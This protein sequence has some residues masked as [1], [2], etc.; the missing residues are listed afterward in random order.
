MAYP[1]DSQRPLS[2][3]SVTEWMRVARAPR[4]AGDLT[5][6][7]AEEVRVI[8]ARS[9]VPAS[10]LDLKPPDVVP[11]FHPAD[12]FLLGEFREVAVDGGPVETEIRKCL[13]HLGVR[14][15][16]CSRPEMIHHRQSGCRASQPAVT[17]AGLHRLESG[18]F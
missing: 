11:K 14:T 9:A 8:L 18:S 16:P 4:A 17:D 5:T 12:E 13:R 1:Q 15:G 2:S 10:S 3:T 6:R 7:R